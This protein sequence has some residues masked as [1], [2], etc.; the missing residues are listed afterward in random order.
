MNPRELTEVY[1]LIEE[2]KETAETQRRIL[3]NEVASENGNFDLL[4]K[5]ASEDAF[6]NIYVKKEDFAKTFLGGE[7]N[8][9]SD[10]KKE[11][12]TKRSEAITKEYIAIAIKDGSLDPY[13]YAIISKEDL[14]EY[15]KDTYKED[16]MVTWFYNLLDATFSQL[17]ADRDVADLEKDFKEEVKSVASY[18]SSEEYD[19][20]RVEM[21]AV[22]KKELET[23]EP[24]SEKRRLER[25]IYVMENR[26][27]L[28]FMFERLHTVKKEKRNLIDTFFNPARSRY[29]MDRFVEKSSRFGITSNVYAYL[30]NIEQTF[31]E[32]KYHVFNNFFLFA[33]MRY[34]S[35]ADESQTSEVKEIIHALLHL[36]TNRFY[37]EEPK[38]ILLNSIREFLDEFMDPAIIARFDRD[39]TTHPGHPVRIEMDKRREEEYK[40][41][42]LDMITKEE[43]LLTESDKEDLLKLSGKELWEY[44]LKITSKTEE[45]EVAEEKSSE[46][47]EDTTEASCEDAGDEEPV[48]TDT[49]NESEDSSED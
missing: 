8:E 32:E 33:A 44:Y 25:E 46:S 10:A 13:K 24:G 36:T 43:R 17:D 12:A 18:I 35:H 1:P 37:S 31:L 19:K 38:N 4:M 41:N 2:A 26:F 34:I 28:A 14:D 49:E 15:L 21:I 42:V 39:N 20:K 47:N 7:W 40:K 29:V 16:A 11:E 27:T 45:S 5:D 30:F 22:K 23:M 9:L 3:S 6:S 48:D